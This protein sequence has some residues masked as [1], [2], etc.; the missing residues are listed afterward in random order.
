MVAARAGCPAVACC[1][2]EHLRPAAC[3]LPAVHLASVQ[4]LVFRAACEH[5]VWALLMDLALS[6]PI[7]SLKSPLG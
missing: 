1:V 3:H 2:V 7:A 5:V 4:F 6:V